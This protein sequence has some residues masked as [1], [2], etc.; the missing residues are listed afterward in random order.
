MLN[1]IKSEEEG[2]ASE[3]NW[4]YSGFRCSECENLLVQDRD[5]GVLKHPEYESNCILSDTFWNP[6]LIRQVLWQNYRILKLYLL[7]I[8]MLA[9]LKLAR[10]APINPPK[11]TLW[12]KHIFLSGIHAIL[13]GNGPPVDNP[14]M[15]KKM[16]DYSECTLCRIQLEPTM[17]PFRYIHPTDDCSMHKS[18]GLTL[19]WIQPAT[20]KMCGFYEYSW[21]WSPG[22]NQHSGPHI[23]P[24]RLQILFWP[25]LWTLAIW[26]T[27]L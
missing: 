7:S 12:W 5:T 14:E 23:L 22:K 9:E 16:F 21:T 15:A 19:K 11:L 20:D 6:G 27:D 8:L 3:P 18:L 4:H 13:C 1:E 2:T 26:P 10:I 25:W 17:F 24:L